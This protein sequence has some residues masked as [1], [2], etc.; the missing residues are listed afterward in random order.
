MT[1]GIELALQFHHC[2]ELVERTCKNVAE[3][4]ERARL[5]AFGGEWGG[6]V[7]WASLCDSRCKSNLIWIEHIEDS[8]SAKSKPQRVGSTAVCV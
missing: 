5:E 7:E 1:Q 4:N 8:D 3:C 6:Q 2:I